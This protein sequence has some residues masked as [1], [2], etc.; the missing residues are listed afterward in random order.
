MLAPGLLRHAEPDY[1]S[2]ESRGLDFR[3]RDTAP[4]SRL[5][6][7]QAHQA[8]ARFAQ[9]EVARVVCSPMTRTLQTAA[10]IAAACGVPLAVDI[11]FREWDSGLPASGTYAKWQEATDE[12][13]RHVGN[14]PDRATWESIRHMR[15][16]ANMAL[17]RLPDDG[18]GAL[19]VTHAFVI[20]A[21]TG[22]DGRTLQYC[23]LVPTP[24][25]GWRVR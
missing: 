11:D 15:D 13:R 20:E 17:S 6:E 9:L 18:Y 5:G 24:P 25:P 23:E 3:S 7:Q 1:D 8:A 21:V 19:V 16:R 12:F 22:V 10:I 2:G 14:A 4:L